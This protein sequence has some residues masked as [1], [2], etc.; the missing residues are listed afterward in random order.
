M[1]DEAASEPGPRARPDAEVTQ[2]EITPAERALAMFSL[3]TLLRRAAL[4]FLDEQKSPKRSGVDETV[5]STTIKAISHVDEACTSF[6]NDNEAAVRRCCQTQVPDGLIDQQQLVGYWLADT[7]GRPLLTHEDARLIGQRGDNA[8]L[9][10]KRALRVKTKKPVWR[11]AR[12]L[13]PGSHR[14][15]ADHFP[16]DALYGA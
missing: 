15:R 13:Y 11:A 3:Q 1:T 14:W 2:P 6:W 9:K 10:A 4:M 7:F 16:S 12:V 5:K 8:M